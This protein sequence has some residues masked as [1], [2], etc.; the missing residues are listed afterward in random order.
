MGS[1]TIKMKYIELI[2]KKWN[3]IDKIRFLL[4]KKPLKELNEIEI[5]ILIEL[6]KLKDT[7]ILIYLKGFQKAIEILMDKKRH[8]K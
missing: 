1:K 4:D 7:E 8:K 5:N 6:N 3:I 2:K